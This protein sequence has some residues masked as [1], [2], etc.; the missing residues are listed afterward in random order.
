MVDI[1]KFLKT[2]RTSVTEK[3]TSPIIGDEDKVGAEKLIEAYKVTD[4]DLAAA[5]LTTSY[6][7]LTHEIETVKKIIELWDI[8]RD[9]QIVQHKLDYTAAILATGRIRDLK[10]KVNVPIEIKQIAQNLKNMMV[11]NYDIK[12][13]NIA[14]RDIACAFITA[15]YVSRT[16]PIETNSQI[17][18]LWIDARS[19]L[20][21]GNDDIDTIISILICGIIRGIKL[22]KDWDI[23]NSKLE[24][25]RSN[26]VL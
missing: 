16:P 14:Q 25:I 6:V 19:K 20:K 26:L 15:T 18:D 4:N 7:F 23:L 3:I 12:L 9:E 10:S 8:I 17:I 2:F 5:L 13:E 24:N 11:E 21:L 1:E 22:E